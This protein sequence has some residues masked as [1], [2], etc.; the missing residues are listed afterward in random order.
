M[1]RRFSALVV[2]AMVASTLPTLTAT[3]AAQEAD[4]GDVVISQVYGGGGN[5]G[6]FYRNDFVELFNQGDVAQ[7]ITGWSLQYTSANGNTWGN[8]STTLPSATIEPGQRY[9]VEMAAG[10]NTEA[11]P[12]PTPDHSA[13]GINMAG[14]N[15]K[16]ALASSADALPGETCPTGDTVVDAVG[17]GTQ[18]CAEI[19]ATTVLNNN[20]SALRDDDRCADTFSIVS[21]PEPENSSAPLTPC[22]TAEPIGPDT[23][24]SQVYGGGGNSGAFYRND[25]VELFNQ[26]DV[27]Q[28]IT[29]WSLQYTSAN[30]NTWGN[31]STTLPSATIE[32][33]QRYLVEMAAGAN[34]EATPLPTPD[35]SATGINMAGTNG[36][37]ALASS[38]DAL[39][40][41]TC[42]TGDTVVDAVGF[43]TQ[44]CAEIQATTVLNNNASA[45][46]DDDRCADTFSIVS[47][48]EPENS[49]APL[50]P[51]TGPVPPQP[52]VAE[53]SDLTVLEGEAGSATQTASD[54]DGTVTQAIITDGDID[55]ISLGDVTPATEVG[56]TLSVELIAADSLEVGTYDLEL[57]FTNDD[58]EPQ[59]ATCDVTVSVQGDLCEVPAEDVTFIHEIQ[60]DG[61]TTPLD[62]QTVVTRGVVTTDFTS[63]GE[64][65][66]PA[67]QGFRGFHIEAIEDDRDD[68][69]D[70]SEGIFIFDGSGTFEPEI[71]TL[72]H[73]EGTAGEAFN[74]TQVDADRIALC[75]DAPGDLPP[76]ATL[77]LPTP[78]DQRDAEFERLESMR[79]T[80]P[81]LTVVEFFQIERFGEIRLSSGG[82]LQNPTNVVAPDDDEAYNAIAEFNSA[83]NIVL[84]DGR[85][86]QNLDPLPYVT[87]GDTLRIGDQAIDETFVLHYAFNAWRLQPIDIDELTEEFRTNRTRPRPE[88]PPEVGGTLTVG[89]F[90]VLNY[91]NGDGYFVG[92]D[93]QTASGFPTARGARSVAEFERQTEKIVDAIIRMDADILG[94]IEIENDEGEDQA[95][96]AL[97]DAVNTTAGEDL[98]DYLDTGLIGT[99]AIKLAFI[100]KPETVE[101]SGDYAILDSSVDER[102]NDQRSRPVLAQTF[103]ELAT[104]ESVTVANNHLKSKGSGCGVGDDDPRQG[105]CNLTRTLAAEAMADWLA[106]DPTGEDASGT[107]IIGDLNSYAKEDP[108]AVLL[109]AGYTDL[110]DAF[111]PEDVMPYTYTFDATQGYLDY[112]LADEELFPYVTGAAAWNIN[113][114]EVPA[115]D[116]LLSGNG[117]FRT[118]EVAELFYDDSAFRSSDHDPVLVGL[119][120]DPAPVNTPPTVDDLTVE[121]NQD[122]SVNGQLVLG[123]EDGDDLT[124]TYGDPEN[125]TVTGDDDGAFTYT[126]N[127]GFF[128]TDTF[129]VTV[130]DGIDQATATVTVN[131]ARTP[132]VAPTVENLALTT[133]QDTSVPGQLVITNADGDPLTVAYG[134]PGN[135]VVTGNDEGA[136]TYTPTTGFV[137]TDTFTVTVSDD[138][139]G[140]DTATVT[141]TVTPVDVDPEDEFLECPSGNGFEFPDVPAGNVH[142]DNIECGNALG[143]LQGLVDGRFN[144]FGSLTR[145]QAASVI[146]RIANETGRPIE[147][148]RR[149][150]SDVTGGPHADAIARLGGAGVIAGFND[151]TFRPNLPVTRGQL[152]TLLVRYIESTTGETLALGQPFPDVPANSELGVNLRK[153]RAAGIFNGTTSGQALPQRT[154]QR[155][156]AASLFVRSLQELP[157][158][159]D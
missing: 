29:G 33:G 26:G 61:A 19:Q 108:I 56:G 13:T 2:A 93:P 53:C 145:G 67:N 100:Y 5:S 94:L 150:F 8:N 1:R 126:P 107:M 114:D 11:T 146:D 147:G 7:D 4:D 97:V 119:D 131:V 3:A 54:A 50:T 118:A 17:F 41:E 40:G 111:S 129:T 45:L 36:K 66:I 133:T 142:S 87:P 74:I 158:A 52:V 155:D 79:V 55:G 86:G 99:D 121:A 136:F 63:G 102:F 70:T 130:S 89:A 137:G 124:V 48:P 134:T 135:G 151:G 110:L 38:A 64:S 113:A 9:L 125:G 6:A 22:G 58:T 83:N 105:S 15:G 127:A 103:T 73:V 157:I 115:I 27:A 10:A 153:A 85:S 75:D 106:D 46:R 77:P 159:Q 152:A 141:I 20:A 84:D 37:I 91:F 95:A 90:N 34:T 123:D 76:A 116:Y 47:P 138:R 21:P 88:T 30:G 43:G 68:D 51:C 65:G 149:S 80:H 12:L 60:G 144:P 18:N 117:R 128:G 59:S 28:D 132:N 25:F 69:P 96:A 92:D 71:G 154:I 143:L 98:Y 49:S 104:G 112:A 16:I 31:N 14:T 156:Q 139:G 23:V 148:D 32:P 101:L 39:P 62:G 109:D 82:V 120:L 72:V 122:E 44:N 35:H 78:V 24:I 42:P 140:S 81:E 57:T